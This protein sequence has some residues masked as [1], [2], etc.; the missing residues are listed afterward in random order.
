MQGTTSGLLARTRPI[1]VACLTAARWTVHEAVDLSTTQNRRH[2]C[3]SM[4]D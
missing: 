1:A 3:Q 4:T 2:D